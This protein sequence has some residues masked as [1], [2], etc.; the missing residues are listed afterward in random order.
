MS[1]LSA[2]RTAIQEKVNALTEQSLVEEYGPVRAALVLPKQKALKRITGEFLAH[3]GLVM[4]AQTKRIDQTMAI[5][6]DTGALYR[7]SVEHTSDAIKLIQEG[8]GQ[9]RASSYCEGSVPLI[10]MVGFDG[11]ASQ[12]YMHE[13]AGKP[14]KTALQRTLQ[15]TRAGLVFAAH[16][17][18]NLENLDRQKKI[19]VA[20]TYQGVY[21][22][23]LENAFGEDHSIEVIPTKGGT[24]GKA[25][26]LPGISVIGDLTDSGGSLRENGLDYVVPVSESAPVLVM[27]ADWREMVPNETRKDISNIMNAFQAASAAAFPDEPMFEPSHHAM[28]DEVAVLGLDEYL[29][30]RG[31]TGIRPEGDQRV[32]FYGINYPP[33]PEA[34]AA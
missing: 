15:T 18:E 7:I 27:H 34:A 9:A 32:P 33:A 2:A 20:S 23:F 28:A 3:T 6:A 11:F 19:A 24:E 22:R 31:K 13:K 16:A 5:H 25:S 10:A 4:Q 17:S 26:F 30:Q 14:F 21:E 8:N 29:A 1:S 12:R